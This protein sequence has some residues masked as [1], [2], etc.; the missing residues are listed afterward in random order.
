MS[1]GREQAGAV[2]SRCRGARVPQLPAGGHGYVVGQ[3][4][5]QV[6]LTSGQVGVGFLQ[7]CSQRAAVLLARHKLV[8]DIGGS[9]CGSTQGAAALI[10]PARAW[11]QVQPGPGG[12]GSACATVAAVG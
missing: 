11:P 12:Q 10:R 7:L 2:G 1:R 3:A 6:G 8:A 4:V 9:A 5:L